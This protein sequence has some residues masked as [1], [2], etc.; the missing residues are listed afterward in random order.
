[1]YSM[2]GFSIFFVGSL[3]AVVI[4]ITAAQATGGKAIRQIV[5]W[6]MGALLAAGLA[7]LPKSW[8]AMFFV[9]PALVCL[10]GT[11]FS[12]DLE[13]VHRWIS[14]GPLRLNS[15]QLTLPLALVAL[16]VVVSRW[17]AGWA[18]MPMLSAL[19]AMQ[20]DASQAAGLAV[21]SGLMVIVLELSWTERLL[22]AMLPVVGA[23]IALGRP[24]PLLPV[25]DVE[26][27]VGLAFEMTPV[28]GIAAVIVLF[29]TTGVPLMFLRSKD[30]AVRAGALG[31]FGYLT[32][33]SLAPMVGAFPVPLMGM[34]VSSVVGTWM[35]IG[36]LR[37]NYA[38]S[39]L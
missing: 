26:G 21:A 10:L 8:P 35:G 23:A 30:L 17:R 2:S 37:R 25:A 22:I 24:D 28:L 34:G 11:L 3:G 12:A 29:A 19:L 5:A 14:L 15:A 31:L 32:V 18:I 4:G 38:A 33:V 9:L 6:G 36:L 1:M 20:P 16:P 13:G 7:R 27:I 39:S